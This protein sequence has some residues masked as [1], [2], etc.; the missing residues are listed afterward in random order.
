[1]LQAGA[2]TTADGRPALAITIV[3]DQADDRSRAMQFV[4]DVALVER[5][6]RY[7]SAQ[8]SGGSVE[9]SVSPTW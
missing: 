9:R 6:G 2:H 7:P 4:L 3:G 8:S 5:A 1:V